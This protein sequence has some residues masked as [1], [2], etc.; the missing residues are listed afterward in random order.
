M[1]RLLEI[2]E[3]CEQA[4][5]KIGAFATRSSGARPEEMERAR[6]WLDMVVG[7]VAARQRAW[8]LVPRTGVITLAPGQ[9]TYNLQTALGAQ[10]PD[11]VQF[12]IKLLLDEAGS[13]RN[14]HEVS[15]LR[16][17]EWEAIENPLRA[18]APEVA[19][20]DR[21]RVPTL[22]LSPVPDS[23]RPYRLR[24]VFQQF[25]SDMT[26]N[27]GVDKTYAIRESWNLYLVT[28]LAA[29]IGNGPVRKLPADE[30]KDMKDE[31]RQL[32]FDLEAYDGQEQAS[33]PRQVSYYNGI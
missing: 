4:L 18:G 24:V 10:A 23:N 11:G 14:V 25:G 20:V 17:E 30:V 26:K 2:R 9:S 7:H 32:L 5:G 13:G 12:V 29:Q 33:E 22:M 3:I 28:A 16:R 31:A 15:I 21:N 6:Y 1:A 8:W 27:K 19:Y